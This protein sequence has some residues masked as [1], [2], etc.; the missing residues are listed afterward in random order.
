MPIEP[1]APRIETVRVM[2]MNS[3]VGRGVF[4]R[5]LGKVQEGGRIVNGEL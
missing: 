2:V 5:S 3:P 1:V 4:S